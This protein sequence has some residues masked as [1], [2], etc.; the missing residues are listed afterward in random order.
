MRPGS[1]AYNLAC[2]F[3]LMG[4]AED[5][6]RWLER[7]RSFKGLPSRLHMQTDTDM[8]PVRHLPWFSKILP[9]E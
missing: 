4:K 7:A 9:E 8:D 3:A 6:R 5:C 1:E 2:V